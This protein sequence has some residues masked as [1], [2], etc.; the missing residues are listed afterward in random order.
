MIRKRNSLT[1]DIEKLLVVW[2]EDQTSH[3]IL[4]RRSLIQ[5]KVPTLF[6][7]M[8]AGNEEAAEEKFE[9]SRAWFMRFK[10]RSHLCNI[11][12]QGEAATADI[13]AAASYPEDLAISEN[14]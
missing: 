12:V 4:L 10:E 9:A 11:N 2:V 13:E 14:R 5:S 3:N 8:K 1:T 7:S 6:N